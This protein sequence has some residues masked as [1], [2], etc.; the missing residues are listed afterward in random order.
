M[1]CVGWHAKGPKTGVL[2]ICL[3]NLSPET[4]WLHPRSVSR[5]GKMHNRDVWEDPRRIDCTHVTFGGSTR[6][7][8]KLSSNGIVSGFDCR[9]RSGRTRAAFGE[10]TGF[11]RMMLRRARKEPETI[12]LHTCNVWRLCKMKNSDIQIEAR[13]LCLNRYRN[14]AKSFGNKSTRAT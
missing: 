8:K 13:K 6:S 11:R 9:K 12:S 10:Y 4:R 1:C 5:K 14:D 3:A 2:E 7:A